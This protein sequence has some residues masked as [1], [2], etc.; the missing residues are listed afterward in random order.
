MS[1]LPDAVAIL[2]IF[3]AQESALSHTALVRRTGLPK[4][5]V[6]RLLRIMK[7]EG[8]LS[9]D[10]E[11]R[12]YRPGILLFQI[13]QLYRKHS[14]LLPLIERRLEDF[15]A[16]VGHTAYVAIRD[17]AEQTVL[18]TVAGKNPLRVITAVGERSPA[19]ATSNGRAL[20]ARLPAARLREIFPTGDLPV[21]SQNTPRTL[22][23]LLPRLARIRHGG[24]S[25]AGN[26]TLAGVSSLGIA[27]EDPETGECYGVAVSFSSLATPPEEVRQIREALFALGKDVGGSVGDEFW[28]GLPAER[29]AG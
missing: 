22:D 19:H 18:R 14:G 17:G 27:I 11:T 6:S 4:S 12:C 26:E 7:E 24:V 28:V 21:V 5:S 25:D 15:A 9:Y 16:T 23:E 2:K 29:A 20:L 13:G 10:E 3:S 1:A 8:L